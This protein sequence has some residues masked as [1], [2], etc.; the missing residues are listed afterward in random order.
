MNKVISWIQL[1]LYLGIY[2]LFRV[3]VK[4]DVDGHLNFIR[5]RVEAGEGICK[6]WNYLYMNNTKESP[7][8]AKG[9]GLNTCTLI[10]GCD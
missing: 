8:V 10:L 6:R 9:S 3:N 2:E 5:S 4:L 1:H 7:F